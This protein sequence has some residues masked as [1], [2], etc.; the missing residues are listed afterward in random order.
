[1]S[2][3]ARG[4]WSSPA[5]TR[6]IPTGSRRP[7]TP[8][9]GSGSAGSSPRRPRRGPTARVIPIGDPARAGASGSVSE[10]D[11]APV[12][13]DDLADPRFTPEIDQ[14]RD[15][16]WPTWRRRARS[17]PTHCAP[18]RPPADRPARLRRRRLPRPP[19]RA[20]PCPARRGRAEPV[21]SRQLVQ[22]A[23]PVP[24][25]PPA[26]RGPACP[27]PRDPRHR[28]ERPIIICGLPRTGTTHLH[29]LIGADPGPAVPALLGEPRAGAR[30]RRTPGPGEPDPRLA[31]TAFA[32]DVLDAALPYFKRMHEM[33][34][35]H[36]HE[37]IQLLAIDLSTMLFETQALH[38]V[39]ARP[40]PGRG[41]DPVLPVPA[42]HPEGPAVAAGWHPLGPQVAPAP[43]A[44]RA[45]GVHLPRRHLRRHP[46]RPGVGDRLDG[47]HDRLHLP[48]GTSSA[49]DPVAIGRYWSARGEDLFRAC[50]DDRD[51]LPEPTARS[52]SASTS[53]WP[54]TSP[55]SSGS[56]TWPTNP[57][58]TATRTAME[59]FRG[60]PSPWPARDGRLP[61]RGTGHRPRRTLRGPR[62][63]HRAIRHR[64]G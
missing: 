26:H 48:D 34:V 62:L 55:R 18:P 17:S 27:P 59:A 44:V 54:T 43:R 35:D 60:R 31:R 10:S 52:T 53:S 19:R 21:G 13:L 16:R 47:H 1:M 23:A 45:A 5:G 39:V 49:I 42:D 15:E 7:A 41:P 46:P 51:L 12:V 50:A 8:G 28:I 14:L 40:L 61:A 2:P 32:L 64:A 4:A 33:T 11:P 9:A 63:L 20:L 37:E 36:V 58:P 6:A 30:P 29:N 38:A 22:P 24:Q 56:T 57:S 3:T 25:E